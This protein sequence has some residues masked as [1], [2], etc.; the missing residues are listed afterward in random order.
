[1]RDNDKVLGEANN[2]LDGKDKETFENELQKIKEELK[3]GRTWET[4]TTKK[5]GK[6]T[7]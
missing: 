4:G 6:C 3:K 1:M 2:R 7:R 5:I